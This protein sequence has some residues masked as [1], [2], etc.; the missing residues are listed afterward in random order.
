MTTL[1]IAYSA[2]AYFFS[3]SVCYLAFLNNLSED[4]EKGKVRRNS[5]KFAKLWVSCFWPMWVMSQIKAE[6]NPTHHKLGNQAESGSRE[7]ELVG[8]VSSKIK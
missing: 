4:S 8:Y 6:S 5:P 7:R 1:L 3:G 2:T